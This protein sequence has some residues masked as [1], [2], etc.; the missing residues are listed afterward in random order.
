MRR[1]VILPSKGQIFDY[2]KG[3]LLDYGLFIDWG[4]PSCWV[5]G[6]HYDGKYDI[7]RPDASWEAILGCWEKIPL[8]RCHITPRSLNG[9]D[10]VENLFLMCREC[11]DIAPNTNI[12]EIFFEWARSQNWLKREQ[13]KLNQALETFSMSKRDYRRFV[14]TMNS[15]AFHVWVKNKIGFHWPQSNYAPRSSRLTYST[16]IGLV[17]YF[18]RQ[19]NKVNVGRISR[20]A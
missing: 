2:W 8:Q 19:E 20:K 16:M 4:E 7:T 3:R 15:P 12:P 17:T 18:L 5:C 9:S 14:K 11:H 13:A 10:S 1:N 6:F